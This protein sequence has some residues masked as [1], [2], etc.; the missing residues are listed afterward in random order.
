MDDSGHIGGLIRIFKEMHPEHEGWKTFI[1]LPDHYSA[2][3]TIVAALPRYIAEADA[4]CLRRADMIDI[5]DPVTKRRDSLAQ[6]LPP[7]EWRTD[8]KA[9]SW[10]GEIEIISEGEV[11]KYK[12]VPVRGDRNWSSLVMIAFKDRGAINRFHDKVMKWS[13][14]KEGCDDTIRV[15]GQRGIPN[16][17]PRPGLSWDDVILPEG[18]AGEIAAN[19]SGFFRASGRYKELGVPHKRGFLLSGPPGNGKTMLAKII[20]SDKSL[21]FAWLSIDSST[22]D[23]MVRSAFDHAARN[24][25]GVLL[26]EDL[27]RLSTGHR[28]SMSSLLNMLDGM[29]SAEGVIVLATTNAPEKLDPALLHRPSRF[30][31][32]WNIGLPGPKER[33]EMLRRKGGRFFPPETLAFA[34]EESKGFSMAYTQ[35]VVTNALVIAANGD[36]S[37]RPDHL[38][39]SLTQLKKQFDATA[40]RQGLDTGVKPSPQVGFAA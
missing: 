2:P 8:L 39:A 28:V 19:V 6:P 38:L 31:R 21:R 1:I 24:A 16:K 27:D 17:I 40:A 9:S 20:A 15:I 34:A 30:D 14:S 36:E 4:S 22:D 10:T 29:E 7:E 33:L 5:G 25:P 11:F 13:A 37:P 23:D 3:S 18:L 26:L 32:V 12:A 35:E